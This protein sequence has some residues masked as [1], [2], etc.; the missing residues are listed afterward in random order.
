MKE[1]EAQNPS[2]YYEENK[3]EESEDVGE[4]AQGWPPRAPASAALPGATTTRST[5]HW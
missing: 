2:W 3:N 4:E 5:G 1:D